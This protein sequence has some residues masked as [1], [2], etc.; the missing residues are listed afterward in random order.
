MNE[1]VSIVICTYNGSKRIASVLD[2]LARQRFEKAVNW[3]IILVDNASE[4]NTVEVARKA[5]NSGTTP[6]R[7]VPEP[8][9]GLS[10]A[11][12]AGIRESQYNLVCFI[13]DDNWVNP[14]YVER[15]FDIMKSNPG[16][17][18]LGGQG[19]AVFE[20]S[21]PE[22]FHEF[23]QAFAVGPQAKNDGI[24]SNKSSFLYGAGLTL[25]KDVWNMIIEKG[26]TFCLSDRTG[27]S[28][29]SGG[30]AEIGYAIRLA[31]YDLYYDSK[32]TF[33]HYMPAGRMSLPY[34]IKLAGSFG[35]ATAI[36]DIYDS[37]L[38]NS[39]GF[40]RAKVQNYLLT[41]LYSVYNILLVLPAHLK[42][43]LYKRNLIKPE[44]EFTYSVENLKQK[45]QLYRSYG[46]YVHSIKN[47]GWRNIHERLQVN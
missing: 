38:N 12:G 26:F 41:V 44:F 33:K 7:I 19:E 40:E 1:G 20:G 2:Y 45:L 8:K 46:K 34:F 39:K 27:T 3:E 43:K 4:D 29:T 31:G 23:Q 15:I 25:R 21:E 47:A 6:L 35:K 10:N 36:T 9:K 14:I 17:A 16:V 18:L 37:I 5:W 11:R 28:I 42:N 22:W 32:L 30:D 24:M 13:D